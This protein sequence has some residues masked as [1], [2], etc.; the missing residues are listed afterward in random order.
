MGVISQLS[1]DIGDSEELRANVQ[2]LIDR[3]VRNSVLTL[4]QKVKYLGPNISIGD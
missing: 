4:H 2:N 3:K 1:E